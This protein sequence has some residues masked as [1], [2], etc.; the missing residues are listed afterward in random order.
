[1]L[2]IR[3]INPRHRAAPVTWTLLALIIAGYL[4]Q[5]FIAAQRDETLLAL[6]Y[7]AAFIPETFWAEPFAHAFSLVTHAFLHA[8]PFHLIGNAF[9]LVVF[10][11]NVEARLGSRRFLAFYLTAAGAAALTHGAIDPQG[12]RPMIG[13][14]GAISA[15]LGAYILWFPRRKVQAFIAPLFLPWIFARILGRIPRFYLW[16]L[17]AWLYIGYWA[18][19]QFLEAGGSLAPGATADAGVAW[20]AHVGGF[21][22]GL[23]LAPLIDPRRR[24]SRS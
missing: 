16:W 1:V 9:F 22:F 3:D 17:P 5:V 4:T 6:M 8:D 7:A 13:A 23:V 24:S 15:V 12:W 11:D 14:S 19:I 18:V 21:V 10:G 2:P 20:W